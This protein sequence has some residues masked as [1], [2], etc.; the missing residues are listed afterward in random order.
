MSLGGHTGVA[1]GIAHGSLR[2][3]ELKI[4]EDSDR[5]EALSTAGLETGAMVWRQARE[6]V[7][8]IP[9]MSARCGIGL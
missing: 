6:T 9:P 7:C 4:S 1:I 2:E 8:S 5:P 3:G